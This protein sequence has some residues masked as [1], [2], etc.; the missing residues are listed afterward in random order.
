MSTSARANHRTGPPTNQPTPNLRPQAG[1]LTAHLLRRLGHGAVSF[2]CPCRLAV[3]SGRR[4]G[5]VQGD[6]G[7]GGVGGDLL[8]SFGADDRR[9]R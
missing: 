4:A 2:S 3:V 8:C 1:R 6:G 7:R 5:L 9:A